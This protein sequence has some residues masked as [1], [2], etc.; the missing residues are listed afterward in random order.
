MRHSLD[1]TSLPK[2]S[3]IENFSVIRSKSTRSHVLDRERMY[4]LTPESL[5]DDLNFDLDKVNHEK[6]IITRRNIFP[7]I[8]T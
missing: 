1:F 7:D 4:F 3:E 2:D 6:S 8:K 5:N